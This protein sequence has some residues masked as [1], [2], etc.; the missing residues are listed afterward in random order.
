MNS[1]INVLMPD[2]ICAAVP[3]LNSDG[4]TDGGQDSC[5]GD[6]GGP[7]ICPVN[8]RATLVGVVSRGVGCASE[9]WPGIY[10]SVFSAKSWIEATIAANP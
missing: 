2:D 1:N 9:G 4:L 7:L 3:D 8:G 10:S 6:S 5:Q